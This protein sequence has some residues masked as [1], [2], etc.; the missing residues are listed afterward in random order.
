MLQEIITIGIVFLITIVIH[1]LGHLFMMWYFTDKTPILRLSW[2]GL[3]VGYKED[4]EGLTYNEYCLVMVGGIVTG[5]FPLAWLYDHMSHT[6]VAIMFAVYILVG[7]RTDLLNIAR[8]GE[9]K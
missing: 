6:V 4:Y 1:E 8:R 3:S 7:C 2:K 9:L 5:L